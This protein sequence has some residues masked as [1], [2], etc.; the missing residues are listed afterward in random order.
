MTPSR[1]LLIVKSSAKSEKLQCL[2]SK[3]TSTIRL[4][5]WVTTITHTWASIRVQRRKSRSWSRSGLVSRSPTTWRCATR[6]LFHTTKRARRTAC[7]TSMSSR[8]NCQSLLWARQWRLL[9]RT[10]GWRQSTTWE[11]IT[12][13]LACARRPSWTQVISD[14]NPSFQ[15]KTAPDRILK[16]EW[17]SAAQ[18][19][20]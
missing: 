4:S 1:L 16:S 6:S 20:W 9:R 13:E 17:I 19:T 14:E 18:I 12:T 10:A 8:E 11:P 7:G 3:K 15:Q 2:K 5:I